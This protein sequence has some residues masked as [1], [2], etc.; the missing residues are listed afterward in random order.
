[1]N[2][3]MDLRQPET[4]AIMNWLE[5]IHF[6][7]SASLHGVMISLARKFGKLK[8]L[9]KL[10]FFSDLGPICNLT[11]NTIFLVVLT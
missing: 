7:A 3:D 9:S 1:M 4:K 5:D 8:M 10:C 2:N 11:E 6:T